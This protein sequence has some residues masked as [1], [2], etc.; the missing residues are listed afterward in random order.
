M[1]ATRVFIGVDGGGT[2]TRAA[3]V[4]SSGNVLSEG[5]AGSSNCNSVGVDNAKKELFHAIQSALQSTSN[6]TGTLH[7]SSL[8]CFFV[9]L[10]ELTFFPSSLQWQ[11]FA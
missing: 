2:K 3:V 1:S 11:G 6:V 10:R 4:D 5:V 9:W 7:L 8:C